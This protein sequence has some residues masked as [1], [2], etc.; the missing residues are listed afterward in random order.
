MLYQVLTDS[1]RTT[2][3][4]FMVLIGALIFSNYINIAGLPE[5]LSEWVSGLDMAPTMVILVIVLVYLVLGSCA[6]KPVD[7]PA[8]RAGFL[9]AGV[10]P[11]FWYCDGSR[12]GAYLVWHS[13]CCHYR[14]Q[15]DHATGGSECIRLAWRAQ[16][17]IAGHYFQGVTP[18]W[19]A[20]ILRLLLLIFIPVLTLWLPMAMA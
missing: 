1:V 11:R 17:C 20:D 10:N 13:R 6:R 19:I 15:P 9:P 5:E 3:M 8:H 7:D 18:F 14:D 16:G 4:I 2:S 12:A